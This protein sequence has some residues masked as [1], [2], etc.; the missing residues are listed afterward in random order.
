[1]NYLLKTKKIQKTA[2]KV[3]ATNPRNGAIRV[4]RT[5]TITI[6]LSELAKAGIN[7]SKSWLETNM[8]ASCHHING[9][10]EIHCT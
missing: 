4:S 9:F 6:K 8:D 10:P 3:A 2:P 7:W 1:M 5:G